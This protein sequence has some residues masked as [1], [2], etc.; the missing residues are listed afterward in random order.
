MVEHPSDKAVIIA[1]CLEGIETGR[2]TV[3]ECLEQYHSVAPELDDMLF[4]AQMVRDTFTKQP[5]ETYKAQSLAHLMT[6]L[7]SLPV[8]NST[9]YHS[10]SHSLRGIF[11]TARL[12]ESR[13]VWALVFLAIA[14]LLIGSGTVYAADAA[15]PGEPLYAIDRTLEEIQAILTKNPE[16]SVALH[17]AHADERL[18]EAQE[19]VDGE[20]SGALRDA[21]IE[22]GSDID[23]AIETMEQYEIAGSNR[24][25]VILEDAIVGHD[26]KLM[27]LAVA[28]NS[29]EDDEATKSRYCGGDENH[30]VAQSLAEQY[31]VNTGQIMNW[32]C[33][34]EQA[35]GQGLGQIMLAL[36]NQDRLGQ[37]GP[38]AE[39]LLKRRADGEGWGQIWQDLGL[40]GKN[41][42]D[43]LP[44]RADPKGDENSSDDG[45]SPGDEPG[46]PD[47]AN[48]RGNRD[49]SDD[50]GPPDHANSKDKGESSGDSGLRGRG[51]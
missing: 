11:V 19:L 14:F 12:R 9:F 45:S 17:L 43:D 25:G 50:N 21:L 4:A 37:E 36:R 33:G 5:T 30:P 51:G 2:L 8:E 47:H 27:R 46:P 44:E 49:Q 18:S 28:D 34:S 41:K 13:V 1:D 24:L 32:F 3:D 7:Q 29:E 20:G 23:S 35:P 26:A 6:R 16:A 40:I 15:V 38:A 42:T 39:E 22:Y 31:D 10:L 48:S